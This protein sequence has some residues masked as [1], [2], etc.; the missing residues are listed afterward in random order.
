V[1]TEKIL[2]QQILTSG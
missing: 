1:S 2:K